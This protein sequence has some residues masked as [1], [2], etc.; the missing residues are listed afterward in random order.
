M[1]PDLKGMAEIVASYIPKRLM[2]IPLGNWKH[3]D[4]DLY[5]DVYNGLLEDITPDKNQ[6]KYFG[7]TRG[8]AGFRSLKS[9]VKTC[10][11]N[12]LYLIDFSKSPMSDSLKAELECLR[13]NYLQ[14]LL[15]AFYL[16]SE[17]LEIINKIYHIAETYKLASPMLQC[18]TP[19]RKQASETGDISRLEKLIEESTIWQDWQAAEN[20]AKGYYELIEVEF[21]LS[22]SQKPW[23][24]EKAFEWAKLVE[25]DLKRFDSPVLQYEKYRILHAGHH[26]AKE[27]EK[28]IKDMEAL[29]AYYLKHPQYAGNT[30]YAEIALRKLNCYMHLKDYEEGQKCAQACLESFWIGSSNRLFFMEVYFMFAMQ[31]AEYGNAFKIIN[32]TKNDAG[33]QKLSIAHQKKWQLYQIYYEYAANAWSGKKLFSSKKFFSDYTGL[34]DDKSGYNAAIYII[35]WCM[36]LRYGDPAELTGKAEAFKKYRG[37]YLKEIQDHRINIFINMMQT[38]DRLDYNYQLV[39]DQTADMLKELQHTPL[40]ESIGNFEGVEIIPLEKLWEMA[41][42]DMKK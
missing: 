10:I 17:G 2:I 38:A 36:Q 40:P 34:V 28:A 32:G 30:R 35:A 20:R 41:M 9:R 37:R 1:A 23:M 15:T 11:L 6:K 25:Q 29:E 24:A 7:H 42:E 19:L 5:L 31:A 16:R 26:C 12:M 27:Y 33:F 8:S 14:R 18:L 22:I 21:A 39:L 13:L 4:T 3:V